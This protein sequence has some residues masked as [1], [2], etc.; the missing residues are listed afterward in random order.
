M[1]PHVTQWLKPEYWARI[2]EL[3]QTFNIVFGDA[4]IHSI[5][6]TQS[7]EWKVWFQNA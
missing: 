3:C 1:S 4:L 2:V 5:N 6:E 7:D